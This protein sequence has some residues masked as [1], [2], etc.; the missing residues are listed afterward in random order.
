[1]AGSRQTISG[2]YALEFVK[3][4]PYMPALTMAKHLHKTEPKLFPT[5]ENARTM[6]RALLGVNGKESKSAN[7]VG[8]K[9]GL[10]RAARKAGEIPLN[11]LPEG[12][13]QS[14]LANIIEG[15][16]KIGILSDLHIP[17]HSR[18]TIDACVKEFHKEKCGSLYINGDY[19][20]AYESSQWEK[21]PRVRTTQK[22]VNI[23]HA[24][25]KWFT[26]HFDQVWWKFGN[27]EERFALR[28]ARQTPELI[29]VTKPDGEEH[30][31]LPALLQTKALGVK[32][33][34]S[35][36]ETR[37]GRLSVWHGHEL[38]K[39]LATPVNPAR[40]LFLRF[41]D[42]AL[43]GHGHRSSY[44]PEQVGST[45]KIISCWS[46]GC[47]CDLKPNYAP[48]N[49]WNHG[50]AIAQVYDEEN[51]EVTNFRIHNG[52]KYNT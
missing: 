32:I 8:A 29:G 7:F 12:L 45:G 10:H 50:A 21:D 44:H 28:V 43:M 6:V 31:T 17:F 11:V 39:G 42:T 38:P 41:V 33:V 1:M 49:K 20:D 48:I 36:Q 4:H 13:T 2:R 47:C 22:E 27:H 46:I 5:V 25:L 3:E 30:L 14:K 15:P 40:G 9:A 35:K 51:F 26:S 16:I 34:D 19:L 52:V 23:G 24:L 37:M 18:A